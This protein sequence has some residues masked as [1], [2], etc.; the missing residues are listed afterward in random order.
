MEFGQILDPAELSHRQFA[1]PSLASPEEADQLAR[2]QRA[3]SR[4]AQVPQI[5][6]GIPIFNF[7]GWVGS[8]YPEGT[9]SADYLKAYSKQL[10]TVELNS[11]FYAIPPAETFS[12]WKASVGSNFRFC[13]KFPK[14]VS[15]S[16][17]PKHADLKLFIERIAPLSE[18]L[19]VCFLQL[20]HYFSS[21]DGDRL[22]T[23]LAALPRELRT[24][25]E[26]RNP[27]FFASQRL[28]PEWVD[29]LAM[30]FM[31]A[32]TID[33]PLEREVAHVSVTST[34][35]MIRFLGANLHDSDFTRLK[36][37]AK[38]IVTWNLAGMKEIYFLVHEPYNGNAPIAARKM[39]EL[40][41]EEFKAQS[42]T[43]QMPTM[44]WHA[45]W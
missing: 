29:N 42:S 9:E 20:P 7:P 34:R 5:Y 30:R 8:F 16:L 25:V 2:I 13:P 18:N 40:I 15:H 6:V 24:V 3:G 22:L 37:W 19:G 39:I 28:K 31:G 1:L 33:T 23:L 41:N 14:S 43:L 21:R 17:D 35:T 12:K 38:R 27:D 11:T 45:L 4:S 36:D 10:G 26:L 44:E 32:A